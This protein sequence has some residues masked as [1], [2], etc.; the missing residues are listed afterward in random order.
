MENRMIPKWIRIGKFRRRDSRARSSSDFSNLI[1]LKT[2]FG[3][4]QGEVGHL[5]LKLI[6]LLRLRENH[7][8]KVLLKLCLDFLLL[9]QDQL[10]FLKKQLSKRGNLLMQFPHNALLGLSQLLGFIYEAFG[11]GFSN[12]LNLL[13]ECLIGLNKMLILALAFLHFFFKFFI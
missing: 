4:V 7:G 8:Q 3:G 10:L 13:L 9:S 12:Q 11:L 5:V 1:I 6:Y 2:E